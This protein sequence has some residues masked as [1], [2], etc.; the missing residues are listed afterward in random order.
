M[1]PLPPPSRTGSSSSRPD[2]SSTFRR[3]RTTAGS[4]ATRLTCRFTFWGRRTTGSEAWRRGDRSLKREWNVFFLEARA[5][6][7]DDEEPCVEGPL[8]RRELLDAL[9]IG[10]SHSRRLRLAVLVV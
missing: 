1:G 2:R 5:V 9:E 10:R 4:S 6:E 3:C 7:V 8:H